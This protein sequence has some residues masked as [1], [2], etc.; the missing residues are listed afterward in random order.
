[1]LI[2]PV[3]TSQKKDFDR[4]TT[5]PLQSWDWGEFRK[6]MGQKVERLDSFQVF[7][8]QVPHLPY[9]IGYFPKGPMPT[10]GIIDTLKKIGKK[11]KAIFIKL[12]PNV[13]KFQISN[14]KFQ[15]KR[16]SLKPGKP[17]FTRH[18]MIIDL[19]KSE[20]ELMA[21]FHSKTR[22]NIRLAQRKGVKIIE[23]NS[24]KAFNQYWQLMKETTKRQRFFAHNKIYHQKMWQT[25]QPAGI[26]HLLKA[27][28]QNEVLA[29]WIL[30]SF[31][32]VLYY[33]YGASSYKHRNVMAS[34]LMMWEAIRFGKKKGCQT[35]DLWGT[36]GPNPN[37]NDPWYGFHRFKIGYNP[38][39]IEFIGT[40]DL[41]LKPHL[42][43]FYKLINKFRWTLLKL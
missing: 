27:T 10:K 42:Y 33:P 13:K 5:H 17:L 15:I 3:S 32:N 21:G 12:E 18:T 40:Y 30:F 43:R 4:L 25:M 16:L 24:E 37:P 36:P 20:E 38:Q 11:H 7:F 31:N 6:K 29:S 26:A 22:Y 2:K 9:T 34:N 19:T 8:H 39:I 23:D 35:F 28:Y 14:F 1:M 41:V